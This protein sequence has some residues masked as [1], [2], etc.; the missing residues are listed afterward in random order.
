MSMQV[1]RFVKSLQLPKFKLSLFEKLWLVAPVAVWFSYRPLFQFGRNQTM[2]FEVSLTLIFVVLLAISGLPLIWHSRKLLIKNRGVLLV[3]SFV[4]LLGLSLLWTPNLTRGLLTYGVLGTLYVIFLASITDAQRL[5]KLIPA[6]TNIYIASAVVMSVLAFVQVVAGIWLDR[7]QTLLCAGCAAVQF[8]FSRPN[9]FTIE[10][11]F[12]GNILLVS[13]LIL[14]HR[15][16]TSTRSRLTIV[17]TVIIVSA[18]FLTMSRG[19]IFAFGV[20][21]ILLLVITRPMLKR[22][23]HFGF[24]LFAG[25]TISLLTQGLAAVMNPDINVTFRSATAT[26]INQ[27]SLGVIDLRTENQEIST[28]AEPIQKSSTDSSQTIAPKEVDPNFDGYVE[29]STNVR[30]LLSKL[31]LQSWSK[32][33]Q[34]ILFGVGLGGSG[35]TIRQDFPAQVNDREIVQNEYLQLLLENGVLGMIL[36]VSIIGGLIYSL[37]HTKWLWAIIVVFLI[38][39]NFYSGYPNSLHVYAIFIILAVIAVKNNSLKAKS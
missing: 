33:V 22:F 26:S 39:W 19:A 15:I 14:L 11:Q 23:I 21:L 5:I 20:G 4:A 38:Q 24:I 3:T 10:P 6:I 29:E 16:L 2:N 7:S 12:F 30:V 36:F 13:A 27:L 9:V 34:R 37:R 32:N 17:S 1:T 25:F 28:P 8:G 35:V 31:A 18:I